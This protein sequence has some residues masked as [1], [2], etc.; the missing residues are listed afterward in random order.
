MGSHQGFRL[1]LPGD[2][3]GYAATIVA[4]GLVIQMLGTPV[5]LDDVIPEKSRAFLV[6]IQPPHD[7][8]AVWP[9]GVVLS[10]AALEQLSAPPDVFA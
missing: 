10:R 5:R 4:G 2:V 3:T 8:F 9:P 6:P 7:E 1:P